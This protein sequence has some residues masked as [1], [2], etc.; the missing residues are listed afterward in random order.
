MIRS[1]A[2]ALLFTATAC[3]S[4]GLGVDPGVP[5]ATA[6]IATTEVPRYDREAE[7]SDE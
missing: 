5:P 3:A 2:V 1:V 4:S 6:G 7:C